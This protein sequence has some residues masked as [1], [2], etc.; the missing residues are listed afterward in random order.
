MLASLALLGSLACGSADSTTPTAVSPQLTSVFSGTLAVTGSAF[1]SFNVVGS[2]PLVAT[3]TTLAPQATVTMGFGVGTPSAATCSLGSYTESAR[4][5]S[6]V[7]GTV[8]PGT[9][10]V[11]IYDIGN[12]TAAE[13]YTLTVV[14][15]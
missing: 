2:G 15:P 8:T 7:T 1:Y 3:L 4:I 14:H 10:C 6:Q 9:Y 13:D 12:L 11:V 5:G